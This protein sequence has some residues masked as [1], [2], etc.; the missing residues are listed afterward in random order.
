[1]TNGIAEDQPCHPVVG[2]GAGISRVSKLN[3]LFSFINR[4]VGRAVLPAF[5]TSFISR[6]GQVAMSVL[7]ARALGPAGFGIFT[8]ALGV[9]L[10][11]GRFAGL[12]W[13][14]LMNRMI[15]KYTVTEDWASL[16]GLIRAANG[17]TIAAGMIAGLI[18]IAGGIWLGP[19]SDLYTGLLLGGLLLPVMAFRSLYRNT[20]AALHL[21]QHGIMVDELLPYAL[22]ALFLG[23]ILLTDLTLS[24]GWTTLLYIVA[25][26]IAVCAGGFWIRNRL[27]EQIR[28]VAP[29]YSLRFWMA[30]SLP[31]LVGMSATLLMNRTD[32]LMLAPLATMQDVGYYGA[33]MR[34]TYVQAAPIIVLSTVITARLSEAFAAG[35]IR[36]GKRIYFGA[37]AFAILW[38]AP[39]ALLL[40]V[41]DTQAMTLFF[42]ADYAPGGPVLAILAVAQIGAAAN[43]SATSLM[44]MTG[45]QNIFGMMTT[46]AL[47][48]NVIG[49]FILIPRLGAEGAA[50]AT[51]ISIFTLTAVQLV[52][53]Y[54]ILRSGRFE[55]VARKK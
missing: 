20:L 6:F 4:P 30:T 42:G 1:M 21:P 11:G 46:T 41:F 9:G 2:S 48:V 24:P 16:H 45:R 55:E 29:L 3:K 13:P 44:L 27:P 34:I 18:C 26:T 10:I 8:F 54:R 39:I 19:E 32:I 50:I 7:A 15:P 23:V 12:G 28:G 36:Q 49:N 5:A 40:T 43:N 53:C 25:S 38:S 37:L 51:S 33:A 52:S 47:A 22:M 17:I 35:R 14:A 31:A